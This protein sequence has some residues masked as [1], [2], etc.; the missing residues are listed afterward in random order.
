MQPAWLKWARAVEHQRVLARG[1]REYLAANPYDYERCDNQADA[2]DPLV[3]MHW[4]LAIRQPHP[5]QW[6]V[7]LGDIVANLRDA[8]DQAMWAAVKAHSG[9]PV[10]ARPGSVSDRHRRRQ[11]R[12]G[13]RADAAARLGGRVGHDRA[14]AAVPRRHAGAYGSARA[15]PVAVQR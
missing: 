7:V 10:R 9:P 15:G 11:V 12:P 5:Q 13:H 3:R 8:L 14:A 1:T 2:S 4:R 6:S